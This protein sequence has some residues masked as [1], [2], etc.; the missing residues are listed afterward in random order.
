[1]IVKGVCAPCDEFEAPFTH[2][3]GPESFNCRDSAVIH[4]PQT[5]ES[6]ATKGSTEMLL[7]TDPP[8]CLKTPCAS[9]CKNNTRFLAG[10][11]QISHLLAFYLKV[12]H[13]TQRRGDAEEQSKGRTDDTGR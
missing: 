7:L 10:T 9:P 5:P 11:A 2:Q 3:A 8:V 1:M 13:N 4:T 6:V 12:T